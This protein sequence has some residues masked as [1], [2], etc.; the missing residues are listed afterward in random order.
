MPRRM[1]VAL[2]TVLMVSVDAVLGL[3]PP[4]P[5]GRDAPTASRMA[6][7]IARN[8]VG[9]RRAFDT[10]RPGGGSWGWRPRVGTLC[11]YSSPW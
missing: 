3:S 2:V 7:M 8:M 1:A 6:L 11:I 10:M 5:R 9:R 4:T